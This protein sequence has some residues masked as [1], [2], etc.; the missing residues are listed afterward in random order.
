[1]AKR[2][3]KYGMI[4]FEQGDFTNAQFEMQRWE[5]IDTQLKAL[6]SIMGNGILYGWDIR[7]NPSDGLSCRISSGAGHVGFVAVESL[8]ENIV[9]LAPDSIN[10]L[11]AQLTR[12]S[13]WT[14]NVNFFSFIDKLRED[15][16][17]L[18]IG[19][20]YTDNEK[21]INIDSSVRTELGF[22]KL[23]NDAIKNHKH[24]GSINNPNPIDLYSEVHGILRQSNLPDLDASII[25]TGIINENLIPQID[26]IKGLINQ[27]T[28]THSQL[29]SYI[30]SLSISDKKLMGEV[31][32]INLLQ[33]ILGLK[34][35]YPDIDE[36]LKNYIS[37]IPGISSDE[38]IDFDNTTA[39]VDTRTY[40]EGGTHTIYGTSENNFENYAYNWGGIYDLIDH[41]KENIIIQNN[42]AILETEFIN[43]SLDDFNSISGWSSQ[44][45]ITGIPFFISLDNSNFVTP[46]RSGKFNITGREIEARLI[47]NKNFIS[48]NWSQYNFLHFKLYTENIDH[49]DLFFHI[50]ND[51]I[52]TIKILN[53]NQFTID[54]QTLMNGWQEIIIDLRRIQRNN[55]HSIGFYIS[56]NDGWNTE[57]NFNFNVDNFVLKSDII[58]KK[59]GFIE[60]SFNSPSMKKFN[61]IEIQKKLLNESNPDWSGSSM[62]VEYYSDNVYNKIIINEFDNIYLLV[63][64][65]NF[66]S[67]EIIF[68]IIINSSNNL[69]NSPV[70]KSLKLNYSIIA[71]ENNF[72][73]SSEQEWING[74]KFNVDVNHDGSISVRDNKNLNTIIY[75]NNG[76]I[77]LMDDNFK[78]IFTFNGSMIPDSIHQSL[79]KLPNGYGL[80]T[81]VAYGENENIWISDIDNDTI[82]ELN[83]SGLVR[84]FYGS[85]LYNPLDKTINLN[86]FKSTNQYVN[87]LSCNLNLKNDTLYIVYDKNIDNIDYLPY[88]YFRIGSHVFQINNYIKE[89]ITNNVIGIKL[90][91]SD[92]IT[93]EKYIENQP[94][95]ISIYS[96]YNNQIIDE[97]VVIEFATYNYDINHGVFAYVD[98]ISFEVHEHKLTLNGLSNGIH[99]IS[100]KLKD[101]N[102]F[103]IEDGGEA[104]ID[105]LVNV[106]NNLP[107][108]QI[109]S[110]LPNQI[111]SKGI[112]DIYF[113]SMNFPILENGQHL[114]YKINN[115][116]FDHYSH[117]PI[118]LEN[119]EYGFYKAEIWMVNENNE[120]L[121]IEYGHV[122]FDF[123]VGK[124]YK[125][126]IKLYSANLVEENVIKKINFITTEN[127]K[128]IDLYAPIDIQFI[129]PDNQN[130]STILISKLY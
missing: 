60:F 20:I 128:Y 121:M 51:P 6:F 27:G 24:N 89:L 110:P 71:E 39:T 55:I 104:K 45:E 79:N 30:E 26:H 102:G 12:D 61:S 80:I 124:N 105:L 86:E 41:N 58:H 115:N 31:S 69:K 38:Y 23:I 33:L 53:K 98:D 32:T 17:N 109:Y 95:I 117:E 99:N 44:S 114:R 103:F 62:V 25:K 90:N 127:I 2:T 46:P 116:I 8:G 68:K 120:I 96:H 48:Q 100:L 122:Y 87:V 65:E 11:Y 34:H 67:N 70:F 82:L 112:I 13:Y 49:G 19:I 74:E 106:D 4:Y 57:K 83:K 78:N 118:R 14:K 47:M 21:I 113:N 59:N 50:N 81:G 97:D 40:M 73:I 101:E 125:T 108:L 3:N 77:N 18:H 94:P 7:S 16:K 9:N 88:S 119:L 91:S 43:L 29:D 92:K 64:P 35:I 42:E 66:M 63:L 130:E 85:Y 52:N 93:V 75:G 123:I 129:P 54:D 15:G 107:I 5:T 28:L 36:Y 56:T 37:F 22:L 72:N 10:Y 1:M 126:P 111:Y 84:G 76:K